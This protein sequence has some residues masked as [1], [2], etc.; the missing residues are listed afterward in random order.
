VIPDARRHDTI[1][2]RHACHLTQSQDGVRH[3]VDDELCEG[4]VERLIFERKLLRR[5]ASHVD[6]GVALLSCC[7]ERFRRIDSRHGGRSQPRDQLG[8]E[9]AW[10]AADVERP[11]TSGD[12][13]E[14]GKL[15]SERH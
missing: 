2:A 7:N 10:A 12:A 14:I 15:W 4:G 1:P 5:S 11:L 3:E 13:R 9:C 6:P 8:R